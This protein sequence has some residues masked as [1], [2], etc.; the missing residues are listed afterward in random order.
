MPRVAQ[1]Q[2][3]RLRPP[4]DR[5]LSSQHQMI[6]GGR[7]RLLVGWACPAPSD[8]PGT[9][10]DRATQLALGLYVAY[11]LAATVASV[12]AGR[13]G[14]RPDPGA[15]G[16]GLF[17]LAYA[18]FAAGPPASWPWPLVRGRR[19]R[20]RVCGDGRAR[21]RGCLGSGRAAGSAFGLLAAVRSFGTSPP[22]PSP[23]CSGPPHPR[24][25]PSP[26]SWPGCCWHLPAY[27]RRV[28][29]DK[30]AVHRS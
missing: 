26:T 5:W 18:G 3:R 20:H 1:M 23:A 6:N 9:S 28:A 11:K 19:G 13:L 10:Q 4:P 21:R 15:L 14:D 12:L 16:V 30:L 8:Q 29:L 2:Q 24:G 17:G 27:W 22:A 7:L 25:R